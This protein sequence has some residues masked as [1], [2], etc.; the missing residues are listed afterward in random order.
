MKR[1]LVLFILLG[2]LMIIGGAQEKR[3]IY[4]ETIDVNVQID[5]ALALAKQES[6]FVICQVGGNWCPWCLKFAG[7]I[8]GNKDISQV[9]DDNY[10]FIHVNYNPRKAASED[11]QSKDAKMMERL[12]NP[13]R[14]GFP[15]LVVLDGMGKVVHIQDSALLEEGNSYN[16]EK[17][18]RFF[19][20]WTPSATR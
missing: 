5:E 19:K 3:A 2:D 6:K 11:N 18:L 8:T 17:V 13:G 20:L 9:I 1:L 16:K 15:V 7:F 12:G 4:D 10:V 14:F